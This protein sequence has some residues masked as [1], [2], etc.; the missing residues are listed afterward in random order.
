MRSHAVSVTRTAH[1]WSEGPPAGEASAV[2]FVLHGYA[3]RAPSFLADCAALAD[4]SR[5]LVAPEGLS[6]FY[7]RGGAGEVGASWMTKAERGAEI[8]DYVGAL[9]RIHNEL[10]GN[11]EVP[12]HVLGFSQGGATAARWVTRGDAFRERPAKGLVLWGSGLPP[13]LDEKRMRE[14]LDGT[15]VCFVLGASDALV[16]AEG[17]ADDERRLRAAGV[18]TRLERFAGGHEL[19]GPT[20]VG[21]T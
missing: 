20:L 11:G 3:Q 9:D 5:L 15:E 8:E 16:D 1:V 10:V 18:E 6:R 17:L 14:R 13:E 12:V 2:W 19:D 21:L 4:G 7:R